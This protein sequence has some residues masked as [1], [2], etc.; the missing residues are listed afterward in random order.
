MSNIQ[1][2]PSGCYR[3]RFINAEGKRESKTFQ[4]R[5]EAVRAVGTLKQGA[6]EVKAG[7]R[8]A[9]PPPKT[10]DE[11]S[12]YWLDTRAVAKRSRADDVSILRAH[13]TPTFSG[14]LI[15]DIGVEHV[16]RFAA[17]RRHL[18]DK[19]VHNHLTL[20]KSMLNVAVELGWLIK[21]PRI[22]KPRIRMFN[23]DFRYLRTDDEV[24]RFLIAA[25]DE[26]E[27]VFVFYATAIFTGMRAG[28]I[29][30]LR[31]SDIDF[32]QEH[33]SVQRSYD[34]PTKA[35]DVRYVPLLNALSPILKA[36]RLRQSG[37]LVFTNE[38]GG[39]FGKSARIFQE[40]LRR[41]RDRAG[42]SDV[43][44]TKGRKK[45]YVVFHDLRH[46]FA[47]HYMMKGGDLFRLQRILGHKDTAMTCRYSHLAPHAFAGDYSRMDALVPAPSSAPVVLRPA[48][49]EVLKDGTTGAQTAQTWRTGPHAKDNTSDHRLARSS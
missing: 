24:R 1:K 36:W 45:P 10:F 14:M 33:I 9:P 34:G 32:G 43:T 15:A 44:T 18:D 5:D 11:L 28:E 25:R 12:A 41:V 19:T 23:A 49:P 17:A 42:F 29:A 39:M 21:V 22:R 7:L 3:I 35:G 27:H 13:L 38:L 20:L 6:Y 8:P 46:T 31:W 48:L 2:L 16:D 37:D 40:V 26:H 30:A 47:S 4:T